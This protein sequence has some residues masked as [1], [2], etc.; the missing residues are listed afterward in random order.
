VLQLLGVAGRAG[1]PDL[2]A[3]GVLTGLFAG[4]VTDA[5]VTVGGA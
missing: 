3:Y 4:L 5:I 1:C 2:V